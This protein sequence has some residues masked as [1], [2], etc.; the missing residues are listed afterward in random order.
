MTA[1]NRL[2]GETSPYLRQHAGN[3]VDW[4][5][6]GPEA[7]AEAA[8]TDRPL[9][10]SVGYSACHWCHVMA[11]ESFEDQATAA[12]MNRLFVNV[13]V[14]REERPDVD[15]VYM[16]AV[17]AVSG[18]G[19]WPMTVFCLPDG[20][21][22][23]AGTYFPP[24]RFVDLLERVAAA[25]AG[26]R[27]GLQADAGQL[28][29]RIRAGTA[30][31]ARRPAGGAGLGRAAGTGDVAGGAPGQLIGAAAAALVARFDPEWGGFG[32]A[33]K[34]P[35]PAM[36]EMLLQ[37]SLGRGRAAS[38]ATA[39]PSGPTGAGEATGSGGSGAARAAALTTLDAMASG[40]IYDHLGGGFAR[41]ATD[42]RWLVPHFEKML[43]DNALLA[44]VYTHAWQLTGEDR[45]RQVVTETIGYLLRAPVRQAGAGLSSA[46]DADSEGVEGRYYLW[47][48]DEVVARAGQATADWYGV[49]P[50]GNWEG[51]SILWRPV[52]A[53]LIRPPAVEAGRRALLEARD[54]R[55]RPGLDD[56]VLTEW[57]AMAVAA[58]AEAG[59]ALGQPAWLG[60]A[61]EVGDFLLRSLRAP[62]GRWMRSWQSG[63]GAGG[64]ARH[65]AYACDYA[66][67]AE[68]FTRLAEA[69]GRARWMA[70]ARAAADGL[71]EL[72]W[73]EEAGG[74]ATT[75]LDGEALVARPMDTYDGAVPAANS[76]AAAAL[77]RLGTLTGDG[78]YGDHAGTVLETM[79]PALART[80]AAYS[81]LVAAADLA[82]G[83]LTEVVVTGDR[84]D[85]LAVVRTC[86][87]PGVVVACGEPYRSPLWA[88]R[89]DP[90]HAGLAFVCRGYTCRAPL[91]E[92]GALAAEL[93]PA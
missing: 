5:P 16:E 44:R 75:G 82:A 52:R 11:H 46:E 89:D 68:A 70:E 26:R 78:R 40:G 2:A 36:L 59:A 35:Q 69:T 83:G 56:K 43:Y 80:P 60:A 22:F 19:G 85:L 34:F 62:T 6:W 39:A 47:D 88:G 92:A 13:K 93:T 8:A 79:A 15:A 74:F 66:W 18:S 12:V 58:L 1:T 61:E 53:D 10:V 25:W 38:G 90:G 27:D 30:M 64:R 42:R 41:Y 55:I 45:Y 73:D 24:D 72:F 86:Y 77:L 20:R 28:G 81:A 21:P 37:S 31:P 33:P 48:A 32:R 7:L 87:R 67:L 4:Y 51:R 14:D 91:S 84:P 76:V 65:L 57:N 50:A 49:S 63:G 17:Q 71:I 29:E 9:L 23:F 54:R 3:P